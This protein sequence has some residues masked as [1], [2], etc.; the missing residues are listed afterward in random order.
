MAL[1]REELGAVEAEGADANQDVGLP[2][3]WDG[4]GFDLEDVRA[5]GGAHDGGAHGLGDGWHFAFGPISRDGC[6]NLLE[7]VSLR[8]IDAELT[9]MRIST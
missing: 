2:W 5:A 9:G 3:R 6:M 7:C 1:A 8:R 4:E